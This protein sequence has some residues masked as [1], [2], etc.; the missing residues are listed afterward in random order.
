MMLFRVEIF[1]RRAES[2]FYREQYHEMKQLPIHEPKLST[3]N[4]RC[5]LV[6]A[7]IMTEKLS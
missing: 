6:Q 5:T 1:E 7:M 3:T 2:I 4:V